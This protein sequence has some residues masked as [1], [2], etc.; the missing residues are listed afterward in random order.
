MIHFNILIAGPP[1]VQK[2]L[3]SVVPGVEP[4]LVRRLVL[5]PVELATLCVAPGAVQ[6]WLHSHVQLLVLLVHLQVC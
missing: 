4:S 5:S 1:V 3:P 6:I 2:P